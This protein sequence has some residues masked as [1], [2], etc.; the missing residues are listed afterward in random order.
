MR[1]EDSVGADVVR[2]RVKRSRVG[3]SLVM[4]GAGWGV[5]CGWE[6]VQVVR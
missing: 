4:Q 6:K 3:C 2:V 5:G 1:L